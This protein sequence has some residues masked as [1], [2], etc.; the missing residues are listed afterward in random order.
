MGK[1]IIIVGM[2]PGLGTGIAEKFGTERYQVGMISRSTEKLVL[3]Q[4][5]LAK[6]G[7]T[8]FHAT[9]DVADENQLQ[10]ALLRLV[11]ELG[12]LDILQY[13]AVDYRMKHILDETIDDLTNGFKVSVGNVLVATKTVLPFLEQ[14]K[15][16]VLITGGAS[17]HYPDPNMASISLGKAGVRNLALQLHTALKSKDIFVGTVTIAGWINPQSETHTPKQIAEQ[18]WRLNQERNNV[19]IAY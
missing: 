13:N 12:G 18:F 8:S 19:E 9:A 16:S 14:S 1:S 2:G 3:A 5:M 10:T 6:K 15:G 11:K 4:E 7:I 17:A